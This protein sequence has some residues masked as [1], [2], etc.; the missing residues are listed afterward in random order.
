MKRK[1][2]ELE[3]ALASVQVEKEKELSLIKERIA[4]LE[5]R[6][7]EDASASQALIADLEATLA[8]ANAMSEKAIQDHSDIQK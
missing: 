1:I 7:H 4:M 3:A 8:T 2:E 5:N 6:L